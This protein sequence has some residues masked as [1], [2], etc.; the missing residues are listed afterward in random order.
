MKAVWRPS[1][2]RKPAI[3]TTVLCAEDQ[4]RRLAGRDDDGDC[5]THYV[6]HLTLSVVVGKPIQSEPSGWEPNVFS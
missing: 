1:L 6:S 3:V 4:R 5:V 2:R